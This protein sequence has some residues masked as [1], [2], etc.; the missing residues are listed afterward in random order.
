MAKVE[1]P[2]G[3]RKAQVA[4]W[5]YVD[6][7]PEFDK[8]LKPGDIIRFTTRD[9]ARLPLPHPLVFQLHAIIS[10]VMAMKAA[11]GYPVFGDER[12]WGSDG[13]F[14]VYSGDPYDSDICQLEDDKDDW[15]PPD[16]YQVDL[17]PPIESDYVGTNTQRWLLP[18]FSQ[19]SPPLEPKYSN[20]KRRRADNSR[21]RDGEQKIAQGE[22]S[23]SD[24]EQPRKVEVV[25]AEERL[26]AE[27][28]YR[29][30]MEKWGGEVANT[31]YL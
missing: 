19:A 27:D 7:E 24:D 8:L 10:R 2:F 16:M 22:I 29:I 9:P 30:Y 14:L 26:R 25:L 28:R 1:F 4:V 12:D 20:Q 11:A 15:S 18:E 31:V 3:S 13:D 21:T 5:R 23:N 6:G 17:N